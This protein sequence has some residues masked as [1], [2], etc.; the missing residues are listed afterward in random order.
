MSKREGMG[1]SL[2]GVLVQI[3]DVGG[4]YVEELAL[5]ERPIVNHGQ[6]IGRGILRFS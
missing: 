5:G 1:F 3:W 6:I 2:G 4:A